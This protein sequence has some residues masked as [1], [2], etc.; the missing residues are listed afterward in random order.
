[1]HGQCRLRYSLTMLDSID[2]CCS[3]VS[4]TAPMSS[5]PPGPSKARVQLDQRRQRLAARKAE[6][7]SQE[8]ADNKVSAAKS[9]AKLADAEAKLRD[10]EDDIEDGDILAKQLVMSENNKMTQIDRLAQLARDNG[11]DQSLI[12]AA[13]QLP[14]P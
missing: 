6:R 13:L 11:I 12:T 3:V 9:A 7:T 4:K 1:M 10:A 2:S 14:K 8:L 5:N